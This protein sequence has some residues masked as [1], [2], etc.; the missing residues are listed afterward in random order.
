MIKIS[1]FFGFYKFFDPKFEDDLAKFTYI[2]ILLRV[3]DFNNNFSTFEFFFSSYL[4]WFFLDWSFEYC[5]KKDEEGGHANEEIGNYLGIL[6]ALFI[7]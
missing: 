6:I 1:K 2:F 5:F 3:F 4:S 7:N